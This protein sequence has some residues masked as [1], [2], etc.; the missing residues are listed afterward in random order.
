[1]G[2]V[3]TDLHIDLAPGPRGGALLVLRFDCH[4]AS[5]EEGEAWEQFTTD[6]HLVWPRADGSIGVLDAGGSFR[7]VGGEPSPPYRIDVWPGPDGLVAI[8]VMGARRDAHPPDRS[9][10]LDLSSL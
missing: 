7:Q 3:S 2:I 4:D 5:R 8:D 6:I 1:V 10:I 9:R